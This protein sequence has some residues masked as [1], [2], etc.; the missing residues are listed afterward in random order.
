MISPAFF[1]LAFDPPQFTSV[2]HFSILYAGPGSQAEV[3]FIG[4]VSLSDSVSSWSE[5]AVADATCTNGAA[6]DMISITENIS[7]NSAYSLFF[8]IQWL[9]DSMV[10]P[11][12]LVIFFLIYS[13]PDFLLKI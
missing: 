8:L 11:T 4:A 1:T 3:T 9:M 12:K 5:D 10:I 2:M 7:A 13:L 6:L